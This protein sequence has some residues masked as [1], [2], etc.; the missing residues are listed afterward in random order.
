[1]EGGEE[2]L[3]GA[4]RIEDHSDCPVPTVDPI[5]NSEGV[6]IGDQSIVEPRYPQCS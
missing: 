5:L 1:M 2:D 6:Q 4:A 3:C